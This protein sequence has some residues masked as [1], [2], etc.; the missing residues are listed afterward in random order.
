MYLINKI[1][2]K[3]LIKYQKVLK[4]YQMKIH[5]LTLSRY[6]KLTMKKEEKISKNL[7]N[8]NHKRE[9]IPLLTILNL[10]LM[11]KN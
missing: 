8:Q 6:M 10:L 2:M 9:K 5:C 4:K 7:Q 1:H 11:K 3:N